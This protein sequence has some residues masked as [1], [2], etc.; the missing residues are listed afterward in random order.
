TQSFNPANAGRPPRTWTLTLP[1]PRTVCNDSLAYN[2]FA[3]RSLAENRL[4]V[5]NCQNGSLVSENH[6]LVSAVGNL[7][8]K[9]C[10]LVSTAA[11]FVSKNR[12]TLPGN[13]EKRKR[14]FEMRVKPKTPGQLPA[15]SARR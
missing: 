5:A 4:K 10:H 3:G 9:K 8:S 12:I 15:G 6:D 13:R 7:S 14:D 1:H 2:G 11:N